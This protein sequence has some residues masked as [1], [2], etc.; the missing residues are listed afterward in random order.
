MLRKK[1]GDLKPHN[2][3]IILDL[4]PILKARNIKFPSAFLIK[5]GINNRTLVKMM[6]GEAVQVNFRQLTILCMNLNC[7]PNDLF[8]LRDMQLPEFHALNTLSVAGSEEDLPSVEEWLSGKSIEE[9][10]TILR[11]K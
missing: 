8:V 5:A 11:G 10:K 1:R 7:T 4:W 2:S 6:N 9:V 3:S